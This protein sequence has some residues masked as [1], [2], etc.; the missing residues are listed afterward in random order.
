M[1]AIVLSW[2]RYFGFPKVA[3]LR[4]I[5]VVPSIGACLEQIILISVFKDSSRIFSGSHGILT[6]AVRLLVKSLVQLYFQ[7]VLSSRH[8][9]ILWFK[10][11]ILG[12]LGRGG[13]CVYTGRTEISLSSCLW[14]QSLTLYLSHPSV[15]SWD[16]LRALEVSPL[17]SRGVTSAA[18]QGDRAPESCFI[19]RITWLLAKT[20][21]YL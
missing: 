21:W 6:N 5:I 19:S 15:L 9:N 8:E 2:R 12:V 4:T 1:W 18:P 13:R 17:F 3:I 14:L 16:G 20:C 10:G 11:N 7:K